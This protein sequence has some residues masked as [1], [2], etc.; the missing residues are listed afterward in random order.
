MHGIINYGV[1]KL[2]YKKLIT[3]MLIILFIL[4]GFT[5][6][7]NGTRSGVITVSKFGGD[8]NTIQEALDNAKDSA[9]HPVTILINPGTYYES[10]SI[11]NGRF[12][13]LIGINKRTC[14]IRNDSGDYY[15]APLN[16][17]GNV[18]IAN[19]TIIATHDAGTPYKLRSYAIHHDSKGVGTSEIYNCILISKQNSAIGIGLQDKQTLIIDS[20]E[21]YKQDLSD[22]YDGGALYIHNQQPNGATNQKLIVKN[23]RIE[24]EVGVAIRVEDANHR[25]TGGY[26]DTRD[27]TISF[28]NNVCWSKNMLK[29]NIVAGDSPLG[30]GYNFGYIKLTN[31]SFGN[32]V[33]VLNVP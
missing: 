19:L 9:L 29:T 32:N 13:S 3:F 16:I 24:S 26:G 30:T 6:T 21:L 27:T 28:Y 5:F 4:I 23:S 14:I 8:Y 7:Q 31:D 10:L 18:Y 1:T 25:T 11:Y 12:I 17:A 22:P 20:C 2:F 15:K 33:S